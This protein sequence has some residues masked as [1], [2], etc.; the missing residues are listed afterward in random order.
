ML[1]EI[2]KEGEKLIIEI[3]KPTGEFPESI[4][5]PGFYKVYFEKVEQ[6]KEPEFNSK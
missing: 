4:P 1:I 2:I 6:E 5:E 3:I